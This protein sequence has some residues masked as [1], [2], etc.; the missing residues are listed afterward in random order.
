MRN[1]GPSQ[2]ENPRI[3][4]KWPIFQLRKLPIVTGRQIVLDLAQLLFNQMKVI[5]QPFRRWRNGLLCLHGLRTS[6][7]RF[8]QEARVFRHPGT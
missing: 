2:A 1:I 8:K 7:V 4:R 5:K 3:P 6:S